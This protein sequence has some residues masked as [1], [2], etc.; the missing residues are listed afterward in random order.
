MTTVAQALAQTLRAYDTDYYFCL[1]GGDHDLWLALHDAGIRIVNCR[2][3]S[4]AAYMA[5]GY[6]RVSG[7][8]GFVYGQRGPGVAN[9][10]A[11]L[12]DPYWG[13]S[14]VVSLT[15]S[16]ALAARDRFQYQDVDTLPMHGPVTIWNKELSAADRVGDMVRAAIRAATGPVPGPVHLEI[17]AD[18]LALPTRAEVYADAGAGFVG[19]YRPAPDP[20]QLKLLLTRL[21]AA[22]RPLIVAGNGV[23]LSQ[24]WSELG[25]F[26]EALS[27][28]VANTL[29]GKGAID[30]DN[31]LS[32]G[33]IGRYS[34]RVANEVVR[35][36]DVVLVVG[37]RL[38]GLAT[39][40]W[41]LPFGDLELLQIDIDPAMIGHNF[42][43]EVGVVGDARA[44]LAEL[45]AQVERSQLS[46]PRS[47]WASQVHERVARW[48]EHATALE[49]ERPADGIHPATALAALRR[50]MAPED[51]L[52]ADTGAIAAWA[53]TLFP[54][55]VGRSFIRSAGSLGW[56]LPAAL[57][58]A[59][60]SPERRTVALT[61]DGGLLYHVGELETAVRCRIP[62]VAVVLN[63]RAFASEHHLLKNIWHRELP[64][65]VDFHDVDFAAVAEGFG[66]RGFR[67]DRA[68][69]LDA[70]L[71]A[72]FALNAPV[73]VDIRVSK[74]AEAPN[75]SMR[76]D[77]LV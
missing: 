29:G 6:A 64:E 74:E 63:N 14:P 8:P 43:A 41:T 50:V 31:D 59:L 72:A 46:R 25:R 11:A 45:L 68:E 54:V 52:A 21:T 44:T 9:V 32:V 47:A 30:E 48:R 77:S 58:A 57:G 24:A 39:H 56:V 53:A 55:P 66:V 61:G 35:E 7:R 16:I 34:R 37:T 75:E 71:V 51:L 49:S 33:T 26:A 65:V 76:G 3:E 1:T 67:V 19:A 42:R 13:L 69:Q 4:A 17:P 10:A 28:P 23:I 40:A 70:T 12:A 22:Q 20:E 5:D 27:I 2:S 15:S 62:V 60:A 38:G 18:M 73:L 36:A